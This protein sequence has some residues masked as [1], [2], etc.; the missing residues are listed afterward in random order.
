MF[1]TRW[2]LLWQTQKLPN[3]WV[4]DMYNLTILNIDRCIKKSFGF[5][6][7]Q[8]LVCWNAQCS[9]WAAQQPHERARSTGA[10]GLVVNVRSTFWGEHG[11][12]LMH[13]PGR[14]LFG[15]FFTQ[16]NCYTCV[17]LWYTFTRKTSQICVN[18][19]YTRVQGWTGCHEWFKLAISLEGFTA[20]VNHGDLYLRPGPY[21]QRWAKMRFL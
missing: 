12:S 18:R 16:S 14:F 7:T 20:C 9:G 2:E 10:T 13:M 15:V 19:T 1:P 11:R 21:L 4:L 8:H 3:R 17:W 6:L 5:P